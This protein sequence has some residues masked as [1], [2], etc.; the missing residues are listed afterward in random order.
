MERTMETMPGSSIREWAG[1]ADF[2]TM[3]R[4]M[5]SS[6][7]ADRLDD[8]DSADD[9][10]R[11]CARKAAFDVSKDVR[12][13]EVDGVSVGYVRVW[14]EDEA[15][16][17]RVYYGRLCVK[18]GYRDARLVRSLLKYMNERSREIESL[19]I[20]AEGEGGASIRVPAWE[21]QLWLSAALRESGY[22][23]VRAS[24][25]MV[26]PDLRDVPEL[27][28]PEGLSWR[29][30][31][32]DLYPAIWDEIHEAFRGHWGY[33]PPCEEDY[34]AWVAWSEGFEPAWAIAWDEGA[35]EV[36]GV[37]HGFFDPA[38]NGERGAARGWTEEISVRPR[39]RGKGVARA[40][41]A[42]SLSAL[43]AAGMREAALSVDA[44]NG[45]GALELYRKAGFAVA[46]AEVCWAKP[47]S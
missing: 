45:D 42:R 25:E 40:A 13:A 16:E 21:P 6:M 1:P 38:W 12:F 22:A 30:F 5:R 8:P 19:R 18:P 37:V 23:P 11:D 2:T 20:Q 7:E 27:G 41:L 28:L 39:W 32:P 35:G 17:G 29:E 43:A 46:R 3:E 44:E 9:I 31:T 4:L 33:T 24:Y 34:R 26:K 10:A 36:A 15:A 47:L 14:F